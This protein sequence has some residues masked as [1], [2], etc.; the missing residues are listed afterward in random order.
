MNYLFAPWRM[1]YIANNLKPDGCIFCE[2]PKSDKDDD[3]FILHRG[4]YSFIILNTFPYNSGDLMVAP[5][6]HTGLYDDLTNE[7]I[8]EINLLGSRC[9]KMMRTLMHPEGFNMGINMGKVAGAGYADH[10]HLHIVPR[11]NGDTNFMPVISDTRVVPEA[12]SET[13][14]KFKQYWNNHDS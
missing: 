3:H 11:W 12:L 2:F 13:F 7:E 5:Y 1:A 10:V 8:L 14:A 9:V 6:R 4:N